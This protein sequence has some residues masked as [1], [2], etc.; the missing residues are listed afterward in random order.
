MSVVYIT[1]HKNPD[2]DTVCSAYAYAKLMNI[3]DDKNTYKAVRCGHLSSSVRR[4]LD[5]LKIDIPPYM[6]D[7]RPKVSDV[8]L[9][10]SYHL[11]ADDPLTEVAAIY[12]VGSPSVIPVFS[13]DDFYGLLSVD[14]ITGWTMRE[15][16]KADAIRNIPKIRD[17]MT[18]Q[19]EPISIN[20]YFDDAMSLLSSSK[21]RGLAVFDDNGYAGYVTRRCFLKVPKYNVIL[22]DHNEPKQSISGITEANVLAIIDHHR[23]DAVKTDLPIFIDAQPL[24]STCTI[25]YQQYLRSGITPD[26]LTAKVMLA[27]LISDTLIL[28]SPTTTQTDIETGH[29]LAE[30]AGVSLEDFGVNMFSMVEGLKSREPESAV[31]S[32]FKMY[33]ENGI[34]IGIGQCEVTTLHDLKEYSGD[35]L[36]ALDNVRQQNALN[37]AVLMIT[38]VLSEHSILLCSDYKANRHLPYQQIAPLMYNM[39]GVM[40]R[41]KQLLPE[42]L[43]AVLV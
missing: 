40:S 6:R 33:T 18:A 31:A 25:V 14:D 23:L 39:P 20:E 16:A 1:G 22:M 32:D 3:K 19:E 8:L 35:Y 4:I 5:S 26:A 36:K 37:W 28:K 43:H 11:E 42:I 29:K 10:V 15:L 24:G 30:M 21:K 7:V 13:G 41:K 34:R 27:G 2:M 12:E 38:D 9:N 17:I